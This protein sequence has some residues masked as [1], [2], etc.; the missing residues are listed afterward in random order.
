MTEGV[1]NSITGHTDV[2]RNLN[3]TQETLKGNRKEISQEATIAFNEIYGKV[4]KIAKIA[5]NFYKGNN[6]EQE[7]FS[8]S[9]VLKNLN[10]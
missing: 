7:K 3:I 10:K 6:V 5:Y 2:L 1:I 9:K 4:I 8:Y